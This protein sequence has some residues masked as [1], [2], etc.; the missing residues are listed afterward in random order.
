MNEEKEKNI[1]PSPLWLNN[2]TYSWSI[3]IFKIKLKQEIESDLRKD[4]YLELYTKLRADLYSELCKLQ[5][6][7]EKNRVINNLEITIDDWQDVTNVD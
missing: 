7:F 6:K 4:L 5:E 1:F 2:M 3:N